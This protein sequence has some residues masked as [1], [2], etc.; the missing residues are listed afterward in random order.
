M[1]ERLTTTS[2]ALLGLLSISPMSGYDLQQAVSRSI[3]HFWPVSKSQV[4]A[5]LA[6]LEPLGLIERTDVPQER[7]PDKRL[8]HLSPEG[9]EALDGWLADSPVEPIQMRIAFLLKTLL[10]HR[11]PPQAT[12]ALLEQVQAGAG[13]EADKFARFG[14]RLA[15]TPDASYAR[16]TV[17][18]GQ[19]I[20][21][22]IAEWAEEAAAML[23]DRQPSID[24]RRQAPRNAPELL[25]A[26]PD[27]EQAHR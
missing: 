7:R 6:R 8:F 26:G 11:R 24:P 16:I 19:K 14:D 17:L 13:Q 25:L 20:A 15:G 18:F 1:G 10:G 5:E 12:R 4:Y 27:H 23:P 21:Q 3:A 9:E 2:Y 22:A